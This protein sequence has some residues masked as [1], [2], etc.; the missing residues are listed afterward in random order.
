M[1]P[2]AAFWC[3]FTHVYFFSLLLFGTS[4]VL[5][6][7]RRT[8]VFPGVRLLNFEYHGIGVWPEVG[9]EKVSSS[10]VSFFLLMLC[11]GPMLTSHVLVFSFPGRLHAGRAG[12]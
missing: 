6:G 7:A 11:K 4:Q 3:L 1:P 5:L 10:Y 8:L 2:L 12:V 9:L